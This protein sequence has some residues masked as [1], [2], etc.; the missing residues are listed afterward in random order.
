MRGRYDCD[1]ITKAVHTCAVWLLCELLRAWVCFFPPLREKYETAFVREQYQKSRS[2]GNAHQTSFGSTGLRLSGCLLLWP[3]RMI[4]WPAAAAAA[5]AETPSVMTAWVSRWGHSQLSLM[6]ARSAAARATVWETLTLLFTKP[7]LEP[8]QAQMEVCLQRARRLSRDYTVAKKEDGWGETRYTV[9]VK[10]S[11]C[12][13]FSFYKCLTK[14]KHK[15]TPTQ[16]RIPNTQPQRK[17]HACMH[18]Y[19]HTHT[20]T[21][22]R[23]RKKKK[24]PSQGCWK[25]C[26]TLTKKS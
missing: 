25:T 24:N 4:W 10:I 17:V 13:N 8:Y 5:A 9:A 3:G 14:C 23:N 2:H 20:R 15:H 16:R 22:T 21:H 6:G 11:S 18:T 7:H 12:L 19:I 1:V 26:Q